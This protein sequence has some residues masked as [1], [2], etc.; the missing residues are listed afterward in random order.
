MP[1]DNNEAESVPLA[2][3]TYPMYPPKVTDDQV[4]SLIRELSVD[5][6][7]PSGG[8]VRRALA[9]RYGSRGGVARIYRLLSSRRPSESPTHVPAIG[10]RL[11]ELE[12]RNLRDQLQQAR[13]RENTH[14]AYWTRQV[15]ELREQ[16]GALESSVQ[17]A[18]I[19]GQVSAALEKEAQD[20]ETRTGQLEV[21]LRAFGPAAGKPESA[22]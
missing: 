6:T 2:R 4:Q 9:H 8:A 17:R 19:S 15:R 20:A 5:G 22:D 13:E 11:L 16:V 1:D 18:A 3:Y 10:V 21:M 14:Q 7:L 12:N